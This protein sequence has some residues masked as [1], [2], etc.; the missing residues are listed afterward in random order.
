VK[1]ISNVS[2]LF[3]LWLMNFFRCKIICTIYHKTK[4]N[5]KQ[6]RTHLVSLLGRCGPDLIAPFANLSLEDKPTWTGLGF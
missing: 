6:A 1:V 2:I 5:N 3:G 4:K